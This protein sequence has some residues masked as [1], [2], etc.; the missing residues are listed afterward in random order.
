MSREQL[1]RLKDL[2]SSI[3]PSAKKPWGQVI[4]WGEDDGNR[5]DVSPGG[6]ETY[7]LTIRIDLRSPEWKL[8]SLPHAL[9]EAYGG[10]LTDDAGQPVASSESAI[11]SLMRQSDAY[12]FVLD[13]REFIRKLAESESSE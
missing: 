11:V 6:G 10:I 2:L 8:V 5:I 9:I 4:W 3:L 1:P 12:E 13:P 7:D